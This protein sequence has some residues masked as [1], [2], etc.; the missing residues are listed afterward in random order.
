MQKRELKFAA[1]ITFTTQEEKEIAV[2]IDEVSIYANCDGNC[3]CPLDVFCE[4]LKPHGIKYEGDWEFYLNNE[5]IEPEFN[6]LDGEDW[7]SFDAK[8]VQF[9][10]LTD[11]KGKEI[12]EGDILECADIRMPVTWDNGSF[13]VITDPSHGRSPLIQERSKNL[14]IIGNIYEHSH[15]LK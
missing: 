9:T 3:G 12:Y 5:K 2:C 10:G 15:L 11:K 14:E 4:Q 1:Y 13:H 6:I 7:V 8:I